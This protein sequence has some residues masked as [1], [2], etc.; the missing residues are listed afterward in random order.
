ML[1][2]A[3]VI[4][5]IIVLIFTYHT[6]LEIFKTMPSMEIK[7]ID[8]LQ[9][10]DIILCRYNSMVNYL[11]DV[12]GYFFKNVLYSTFSSLYTHCGMI[13]KYNGKT[14][15][16]HTMPRPFYDEYTGKITCGTMLNDFKTYA[17]TY[18]GEVVV[19]KSK[20]NLDQTS[21][22]KWMKSIMHKKFDLSL[23]RMINTFLRFG[24]NEYFEDKHFCSQL[25]GDMASN[26]Y[27]CEDD[28]TNWNVSDVENFCS[29]LGTFEDPILLKNHYYFNYYSPHP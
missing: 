3:I 19:L 8:L 13:I 15:I 21:V 20:N 18:S 26:L 29:K 12:V 4:F 9:T 10:G 27:S 5:I 1:I 22:E 14:C 7:D 2:F 17:D 25:L 23:S 16:L 28:A 6:K 24:D 11:S